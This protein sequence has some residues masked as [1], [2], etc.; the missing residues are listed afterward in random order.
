MALAG[1]AERELSFDRDDKFP[2]AHSLD[3]GE[4]CLSVLM[5][6]VGYDPDRWVV[7][8][9]GRRA[10]D[11]S[12]HAAWLHFSEKLFSSLAPNRV[13][14]RIDGRKRVQRVLVIQRD[15]LVGAESSGRGKLLRQHAGD[16][17]RLQFLSGERRRAAHSAKRADYEHGLSRLDLGCD[18]NQLVSRSRDERQG[19]RFNEIQTV[20]NFCEKPSL[21]DAEL[22]VCVV[23]PREH[24][25]ADRETDDARPD[26]DDGPGEVPSEHAWKTDRPEILSQTG[27][28]HDVD[29]VDG[30]RG[31]LD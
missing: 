17:P 7:L 14:D 21:D 27:P 19:G 28:L 18:R 22:S 3:H 16:D 6:D 1:G 30:R 24:L 8:G 5:R 31:D 20:W 4:D 2:R 29:W 11:G 13:G 25:V 23:G 10:G 9:V 15:E 12:E 26:A